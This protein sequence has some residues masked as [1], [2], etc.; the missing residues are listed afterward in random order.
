MMVPL[1]ITNEHDQAV[2][3]APNV[4]VVDDDPEVR[5]SLSL[6]ARSV[7][8]NVET[9][10]SAQEFL[11]NYDPSRPG[12]LV[13]DVRMPGMSGLELQKQLASQAISLS[14]IFITVH[15]EIPM[16]I[17]AMRAGALDF[18]EKPFSRHAIL[19]RIHEAIKLSEDKHRTQLLNHQVNDRTAKL[20]AR[21]CQVMHLLAAGDSTKVIASRMGISPKTVD[22]H[23][24]KVFDKMGVENAAQLACLLQRIDAKH[25]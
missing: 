2:L 1:A 12:C 11:D 19:E 18:I 4:F 17:E 24:T 3:S 13:L 14:I 16:A 25:C 10:A 22:N 7:D 8:L 15:G 23:R 5:R 21:E 6:L 9:F 20:S